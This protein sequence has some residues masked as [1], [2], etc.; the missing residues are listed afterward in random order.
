MK[1]RFAT[2]RAQALTLSEVLVVVAV[3]MALIIGFAVLPR[4]KAK[5]MRINC[6][7]NLKAGE[8]A[9]W[10]WAGD[11]NQRYPMELSTN[12]G[13][14]REWIQEGKAFEV[15]RVMSNELST[16]KI[17]HC[18]ADARAWATNFS[19]FDNRHLS[20]FLGVDAPCQFN[21]NA[22][23]ILLSLFLYGDRNLTNGT[24]PAKGIIQLTTDQNVHWTRDMHRSEGNICLADGRVLQLDNRGLRELLRTTAAVTNRLAI[25]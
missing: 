19:Q 21:T 11:N 8:V 14:A 23:K 6:F 22:P 20:Y 3:A 5:A 9:F 2:Q 16:P 17:L 25:P 15:F 10:L 18:P 24:P 4:A 13:G 1:P 7:S 12:S